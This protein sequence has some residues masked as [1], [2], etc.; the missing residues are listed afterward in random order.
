MNVNKKAEALHQPT[1]ASW[2]MQAESNSEISGAAKNRFFKLFGIVFPLIY[3]NR[4]ST[5]LGKTRD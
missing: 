5:S 4:T 3:Y 2:A 1:S